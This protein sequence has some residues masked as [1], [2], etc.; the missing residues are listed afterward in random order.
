M[1]LSLIR[2]MSAFSSAEIPSSSGMSSSRFQLLS[3]TSQ[4][5]L[6]SL[7][8]KGTCQSGVWCLTSSNAEVMTPSKYRTPLRTLS[9]A[10][11]TIL[12]IPSSGVPVMSLSK[13]THA[14][15]QPVKPRLKSKWQHSFP[16]L[17]KVK[18]N[19]P[20]RASGE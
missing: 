5:D 13:A 4:C 9:G 2:P 10:E 7:F 17:R 14:P 20:S 6:V 12:S 8:T 18:R 16:S 1:N 3:S 15:R 19:F 11:M